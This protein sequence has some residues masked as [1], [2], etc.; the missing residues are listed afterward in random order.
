MPAVQQHNYNEDRMCQKDINS[1]PTV[2]FQPDSQSATDSL[3][4]YMLGEA[5]TE[6]REGCGNSLWDRMNTVS[7][8]EPFLHGLEVQNTMETQI[9]ILF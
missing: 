8:I 5:A 3:W 7:A 6:N 2:A 4:N 9:Y 1:L